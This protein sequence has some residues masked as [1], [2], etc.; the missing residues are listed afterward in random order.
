MGDLGRLEQVLNNLVS[1]AIKYTPGGGT[2]EISGRSMPGEAIV[3]VSDTGVGIP[4]GEQTRVFERFFRGA[5][6]RHQG[7]PGAGLGLYLSK[8]I[9]EAHNGRIWVES[10][11]GEGAAFSFAVPYQPTSD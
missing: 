1:N 7:T 3:T 8:A 4:L 5:Q 2:I 11:P 6:Q 9:V 10:H